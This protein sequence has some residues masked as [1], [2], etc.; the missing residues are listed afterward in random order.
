MTVPRPC[1]FEPGAPLPSRDEDRDRD[2]RGF[3]LGIAAAFT[4]A[5]LAIAGHT[6]QVEEGY[7]LAAA[8]REGEVLRREALQAERRVAALRVPTAV[9]HR[10]GAMQ[11]GLA[12]PKDRRV[13]TE[14]QV[15]AATAPAARP[16][17]PEVMAR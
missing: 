14:Q 6:D 9:V 5:M 1:G 7:R 4:S 13:L 17:S 8:R 12:L 2:G 10:A 16:L 11:L 3:A 15:L